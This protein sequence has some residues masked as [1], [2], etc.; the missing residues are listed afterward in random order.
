MLVLLI[1]FKTISGLRGT[2]EI[3]FSAPADPTPSTTSAGPKTA[4]KVASAAK[5]VQ[6][7]IGLAEDEKD[8]NSLNFVCRLQDGSFEVKSNKECRE[9]Y[10]LQLIKFYERQI[11][12][13][14]STFQPTPKR[15]FIDALREP[16]EMVINALNDT[17]NNNI[18]NINE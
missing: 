7:I 14:P 5:R 15:T 17:D 10:P 18:K 9:H 3:S 12:F 16:L 11:N 2:S 6:R 13:T 4:T 8:D 1:D